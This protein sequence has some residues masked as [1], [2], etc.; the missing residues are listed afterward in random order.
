[1]MESNIYSKE[2]ISQY[3][4]SGYWQDLTTVELCET[5]AREY[6]D[7]EALVDS[8]SR[9]TWAQVK[10]LSD[11]IALALLELG[12][13]KNDV[14]LL[15]LYNC[16]EFYLVRLACEKAGV[17]CATA[18]ATFRQAE[19]EAI[20]RHLEAKGIIISWRYR[21]FDYFS[22]VQGM[23]PNLPS[24]KHI[25]VVGDEV[26]E[27]TISVNKICREAREERYSP[28]YLT[29]SRVGA[30]DADYQWHD[31]YPQVY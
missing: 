21:N 30:F 9:L 12:F 18:A 20:L 28:D 24:L 8:K 19:V 14:L 26:P 6:P 31:G 1:M 29:K 11:R 22:M 10:Q 25:L 16:V 13:K 3:W 17:T 15:Q 27:G 2:L 5:N 4:E 7:V 23:M